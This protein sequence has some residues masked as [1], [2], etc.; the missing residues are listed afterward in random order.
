MLQVHLKKSYALPVGSFWVVYVDCSCIGWVD[1]ERCSPSFKW[2]CIRCLKISMYFGHIHPP[3]WIPPTLFP[4]PSFPTLRCLP[5]Y[6]FLSFPMSW[7]GSPTGLSSGECPGCG[8]LTKGPISKENR[9]SLSQQLFSPRRTSC[10]L[11]LFCNGI[12]S[13]WSSNRTCWRSL[14]SSV[15]YMHLPCCAEVFL[16]LLLL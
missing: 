4:D 6:F 9:H 13:R 16:M 8:Q 5:L 7:I 2:Y 15:H 14:V 1:W 10:L 11:F 3:P 12:L